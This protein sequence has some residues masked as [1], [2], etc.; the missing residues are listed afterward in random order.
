MKRESFAFLPSVLLAACVLSSCSGLEPESNR[1]DEGKDLV[2]TGGSVQM[3]TEDPV[4]MQTLDEIWDEW[5]EALQEDYENLS[6]EDGIKLEKPEE[7]GIFNFVQS[8]DIL[9]YESAIDAEFVPKKRWDEKYYEKNPKTSPPGPEYVNKKTGEMLLLGN[10]GFINY[11]RRKEA[12]EYDSDSP[13]V[14][15]VYLDR[16]YSDRKI[17][18]RDGDIMLS[19]ALRLAERMA[20]KWEKAVPQDL[21]SRPRRVYICP[22]TIADGKYVLYFLFEKCYKGVNILTENRTIKRPNDEPLSV[23]YLDWADDGIVVAS[24][25]EA[26]TFLS[27]GGIVEKE[28]ESE[29]LKTIVS[30]K[31]ALRLLEDKM[32]GYH[33]NSIRKIALSYRFVELPREDK[34]E[35]Q[36]SFP[37][38]SRYEARPC[39]VFYFAEDQGQEEFAL[40][41]CKDGAVD[42]IKNY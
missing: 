1:G 19:D 3:Q 12:Q 27:Q 4:Q 7:I 14:E 35:Y 24:C 5:D 20:A 22:S 6:F 31:S 39:W 26:E 42:Y 8:D 40:V 16:D 34:P 41:D 37:G 36:G 11:V 25:K 21:E 38:G 29:E 17:S 15:T 28:G 32:A 30:L 10:Q 9:D 18:L 13:D 2:Q 33:M 23:Q